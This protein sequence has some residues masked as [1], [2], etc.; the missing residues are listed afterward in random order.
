[1]QVD[2][3]GT[4][5]TFITAKIVV[6]SDPVHALHCNTRYILILTHVFQAPT[7]DITQQLTVQLPICT[8]GT[9]GTG[10]DRCLASFTT[11]S[12]F[13]N[14]VLVS[15][16]NE[17]ADL[18]HLQ[19]K[20]DEVTHVRNRPAGDDEKRKGKWGTGD[21]AQGITADKHQ[22]GTYSRGK[23][24]DK[25]QTDGIFGQGYNGVAEENQ[26]K[27]AEKRQSDDHVVNVSLPFH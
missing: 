27:R 6:D 14:C 17:A 25:R 22:R 20:I 23:R 10:K 13:G 18:A 4:G 19:L 8:K 9:G 3:S 12:G 24:T 2:A 21:K 16:A 7:N 26:S 15:Q 5:K 1:M 11:T